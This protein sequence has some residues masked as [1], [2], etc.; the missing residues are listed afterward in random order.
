MS[1]QAKPMLATALAAALLGYA[2]AGAA[3]PPLHVS[4]DDVSTVVGYADLDLHS[5]QDARTL[6][7][8]VRSSAQRVCQ[9]AA[10]DGTEDIDLSAD[11]QGYRQCVQAATRDA[12]DHLGVPEVTAMFRE[13]R[14]AQATTR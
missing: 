7:E 14:L 4:G 3:A 12:I 8:R 9:K 2:G 6:I 11:V 5:P 13:T 1:L 10:P